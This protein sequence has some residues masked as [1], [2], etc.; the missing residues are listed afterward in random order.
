MAS[1]CQMIINRVRATGDH[2]VQVVD[3]FQLQS[4][5]QR[6]VVTGT[7]PERQR[8]IADLGVHPPAPTR[9]APSL[10][11]LVDQCLDHGPTTS[12]SVPQEY[13]ASG[14]S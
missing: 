7:D 10:A 6:V 3:V 2:V 4:A 14:G 12:Q 1:T 8:Q 5:H 11:F 13:F 9:S